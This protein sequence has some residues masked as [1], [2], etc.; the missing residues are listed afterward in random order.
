MLWFISFPFSSKRQGEM[1]KFMVSSFSSWTSERTE[2][3]RISFMDISSTLHRRL[4]RNYHQDGLGT[5]ISF[6]NYVYVLQSH[7]TFNELFHS[8][9]QKMD[10]I[11]QKIRDMIHYPVEKNFRLSSRCYQTW[12]RFLS[13]GFQKTLPYLPSSQHWHFPTLLLSHVTTISITSSP[14]WW[15]RY[16]GDLTLWVCPSLRLNGPKKLSSLI[17][18]F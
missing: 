2:L 4:S 9:Q 8:F 16:W 10:A 15:G 12:Y 1:T 14:S 17:C 5:R 3:Q 7:V 13:H 6:L 18:G 11:T